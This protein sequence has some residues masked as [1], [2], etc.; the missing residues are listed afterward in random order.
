LTGCTPKGT[1]SWSLDT[2]HPIGAD[3]LGKP[4]ISV[5]FATAWSRFRLSL[6]TGNSSFVC[7]KNVFLYID[8]L[9]LHRTWVFVFLLY[10][11][12]WHKN[13]VLSLLTVQVLRHLGQFF[14][15]KINL[16]FTQKLISYN[17]IYCISFL[18]NVY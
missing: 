16:W 15:S 17:F 18:I 5:R 7:S 3:T 13:N 9:N 10:L 4:P 2:A 6:W 14:F 11:F 12:L 1:R 8:S